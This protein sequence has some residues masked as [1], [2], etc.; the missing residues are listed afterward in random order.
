M[1]ANIVRELIAIVL[2]TA[3]I[4]STPARAQVLV[5]TG[6]LSSPKVKDLGA[7]F[8]KASKEPTGAKPKTKPGASPAAAPAKPR[9]LPDSFSGE[10]EDPMSILHINDDVLTRFSA[11]LAAEAA[12]RSQGAPLTRLKY[13]EVHAAAGAFTPRQYFVLK[14]RVR[15]FCEAIAAGQPPSNNLTLSYMPTEAAVIRP[16]CPALLP[17]LKA[18]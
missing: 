18:L 5:E 10:T 4:V 17:A 12:R 15:P 6:V 16:R 14:A 8:D 7:I 1:A 11:A 3:A 2:V 9:V 13:D